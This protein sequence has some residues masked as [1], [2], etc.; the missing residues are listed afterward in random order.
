MT[1]AVILS[2]THYVTYKWMRGT[3]YLTGLATPYHVKIEMF[4]AVPIEFE[5]CCS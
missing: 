1:Q 5:E 4:P 3:K 2:E